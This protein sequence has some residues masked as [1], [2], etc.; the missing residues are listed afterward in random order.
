MAIRSMTGF[1]TAEGSWENWQLGVQFR[2]VNSRF[3]DLSCKLPSK[4]STLEQAVTTRV[5]ALLSRGRVECSLTIAPQTSGA[6]ALGQEIS[7]ET[8]RSLKSI[9]LK[10][11]EETGI[12]EKEALLQILPLMFS[13]RNTAENQAL[14]WNTEQN[15]P[16]LSAVV[17]ALVSQALAG[18]LKMREKE[19]QALAAHI[20]GELTELEALR[21]KIEQAAPKAVENY[22]QKL[23]QRLEKFRDVVQLD[24][25]RLAQEVVFFADRCDI[26]E[27]LVRL[28][29]HLA[30]FRKYLESSEY[31]VIGKKLEFLLQEMGREINTLSSKSQDQ[32]ISH[33]VVEAKSVVE[34]I[35]E[36]VM[37][38]E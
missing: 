10:V 32:D 9:A 6:S 22:R 3:L 14:S 15:L 31:E 23:E 37:N 25:S 19:G 34:R 20:L 16:Q 36:Q 29:S 28:Q 27:E 30:Q 13:Q 24:P 2:A 33:Y 17:E 7:L 4:L 38:I 8:I 1:G 26:K 18:L 11:S 12:K 5:K 21:E 35:K